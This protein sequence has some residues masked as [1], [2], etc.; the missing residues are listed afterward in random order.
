MLQIHTVR[1]R[2]QIRIQ[3]D[4]AVGVLLVEPL[5]KP[6]ED[7]NG[8]FQPLAL[9]NAHNPHS[10]LALLSRGLA[11]ILVI[12]PQLLDI[13]DKMKQAL[14]AGRLI[15]PCLFRQH[16]QVCPPG[17]S[18]G[19]GGH[20]IIVAALPVGQ[21]QKL[22]DGKIAG[23]LPQPGK[24]R[25][26]APQLL[27]YPCGC[28]CWNSPFLCKIWHRGASSALGRAV[29]RA[30]RPPGSA[31][32]R[33]VP[34]LKA[35]R[36]LRP[37]LPGRVHPP[38][39]ALFRPPL[40]GGHH[41]GHLLVRHAHNGRAQHCRQRDI[42]HGVVHHGEKAQHGLRLHGVK[43]ARGGLGVSRD[44]LIHQHIDKDLGPAGHAPQKDHNIPVLGPPVSSR[45]LRPPALVPDREPPPAVHEL[46]YFLGGHLGL[47]L[48][49]CIVKLL[50]VQY[51]QGLGAGVCGQKLR[52]PPRTL[53]LRSR[54]EVRPGI[55]GRLLRV[56]DSSQALCHN[57]EKYMVDA[58]QH[59]IPA[60]E[61]LLQLNEHIGVRIPG[62][63]V[64]FHHKQLRHCQPEPVNALLHIPHHEHIGIPQP[65]PGNRLNQGLLHQVAV[66][67]LVHQNFRELF[68]QLLCRRGGNALPALRRLLPQHLKGKM[69]QVIKIQN[70]PLL[71]RLPE[72]LV[73]P[74][75]HIEKGKE[76]RTGGRENPAGL[77]RALAPV[78]I[79][80]LSQGLLR[81]IPA[82]AYKRLL[83][84]IHILAPC[85]CQPVK[86]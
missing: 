51:P 28:F 69:L 18:P 40:V 1:C 76:R 80:K 38:V 22:R 49:G 21:L 4:L 15:A 36:S 44:P 23:R 67:V 33:A 53:P 34:A 5:S 63:G 73:I 35:S 86:A 11:E 70:I 65:L 12:F 7:D 79:P 55:E 29:H 16:V 43:V 41:P 77:L 68:P 78:E 60:A 42:L 14:V 71:F 48:P 6:S 39:L 50:L 46:P 20:V 19:H 30:V 61:I 26:K 13:P 2:S 17:Q 9:V 66:L 84:L 27:L 83:F 25:A 45:S 74:P 56:P 57:L 10:L 8:K 31:I 24:Q 82:A 81:P 85:G 47:Q 3:Q 59:R 64:I 32:P 75:H 52:W 58:G 37:Q 72:G 62:I 54:R